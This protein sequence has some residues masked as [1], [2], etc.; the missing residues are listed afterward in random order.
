MKV[1]SNTDDLESSSG[2]TLVGDTQEN[3]HK[4]EVVPNEHEETIKIRNLVGADLNDHIR[5]IE[6]SVKEGWIKELKV[7]NKVDFFLIQETKQENMSNLNCAKLWGNQE[8][9]VEGVEASGLSGGLL[10]VWD[11]GI[12]EMISSVKDRNFLLV[13]GR[14]KG[15]QEMINIINM[16]APQKT[17]DKLIL[18]NKIRGAMDGFAGLWVIAGDFNAVRW[19]EECKNSSFKN[20]CARNFNEFIHAAGL[21]VYDLKGRRFTCIRDNGRKLSKID[22]FLV[23]PNFFHKWPEACLRGL[24]FKHSDHCP[25]VLTIVN[26]N[27]GA[28]PFRVFNSWMRKVG[29]QETA[30]RV[31][32]LQEVSSGPVDIKL[33]RKF[34]A[35]RNALKF[36]RA[37]LM[38]KESEM[39]I[40]AEEEL[41]D[42]EIIMED[43]DLNEVEEWAYVENNKVVMNHGANKWEDMKQKSRTRWVMESVKHEP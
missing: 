34:G 39:V 9:G 1:V 40:K 10:C 43:Q 16:Y 4:V 28:K 17:S 21:V 7:R 36:W 8:C 6:G 32:D 41:E 29:F 35:I 24:S 38:K 15:S 30:E 22:R 25:L 26:K 27:F 31:V 33:M 42:L 19:H 3:L 14:I 20:T 12:F 18:W 11:K 2:D 37:D 13:N 23:C 5:G